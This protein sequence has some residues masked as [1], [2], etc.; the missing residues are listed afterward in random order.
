MIVDPSPDSVGLSASTLG[1]SFLYKNIEIP[2]SIQCLQ[3]CVS[4]RASRSLSL[5]HHRDASVHSIIMALT[6]ALPTYGDFEIHLQVYLF[7]KVSGTHIYVHGQKNK[8]VE[9]PGLD[10]SP[11]NFLSLPTHQ[12]L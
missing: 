11:Q 12:P 7:E 10:L 5:Q 4:P 2:L 8:E 3:H 9:G 1:S 6:L